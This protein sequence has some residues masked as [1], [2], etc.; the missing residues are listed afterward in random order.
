M[1]IIVTGVPGTGKSTLAKALAKKMKCA[2]IDV[3]EIVKREKLWSRLEE[4]VMVV[5]MKELERRLRERAGSAKN[6]V[7]DG[8]LACELKIPADLVIVTRT[9]PDMLKKRLMKRDYDKIT[10]IENMMAEAHDYCTIL[11]E[12]RYK[13]VREVVTD[14]KLADALKQV[15][16]IMKD[17]KALKAGWV[18]WSKEFAKQC[19]L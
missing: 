16:K 17:P 1:K 12:E 18:A 19:G 6:Y 5:K 8:H 3:N 10:L 2:Y 14:K 9:N 4:G 15:G 11:S 7:V 13:D